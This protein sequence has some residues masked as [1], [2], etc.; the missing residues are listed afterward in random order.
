MVN[1]GNLDLCYFCLPYGFNFNEEKFM[2]KSKCL[3]RST[4]TQIIH[5]AVLDTN[6]NGNS[7]YILLCLQQ[8]TLSAL[9]LL[10]RK[11]IYTGEAR[12]A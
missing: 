12:R 9:P 7:R 4:N 3:L 5:E 8:H 2:E 6:P 10:F 11:R 1:K